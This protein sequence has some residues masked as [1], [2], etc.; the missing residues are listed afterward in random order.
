MEKQFAL[1]SAKALKAIK[2]LAAKCELT[3][4]LSFSETT[5][6]CQDGP[7]VGFNKV[8]HAL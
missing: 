8:A 4:N 2:N 5:K 3:N 6:C 1:K 7:V